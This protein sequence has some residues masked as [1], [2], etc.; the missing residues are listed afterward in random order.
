M[1]LHNVN[2]LEY[3]VKAVREIKKL[4][5]VK[6]D[7]RSKIPCPRCKSDLHFSI[8]AYNGHIWGKCST[9]DCIRWVE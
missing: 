3:I 2:D 6:K 7:I 4:H 1:I 5:P 8:T 9:K